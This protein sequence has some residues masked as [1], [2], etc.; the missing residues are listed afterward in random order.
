MQDLDDKLVRGAEQER[1][2]QK[3]IFTKMAS[4]FVDNEEREKKATGL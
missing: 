4:S 3:D 1:I 2:I